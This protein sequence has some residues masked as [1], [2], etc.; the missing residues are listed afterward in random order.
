MSVLVNI[1]G[2]DI[3]T[4]TGSN[5]HLIRE[6]SGLDPWCCS[7]SQVKQVLGEKL[8]EVPAQDLWRLAY[9]GKLLEQ[10]GEAHHE[11]LDTREL[12]ELIDSLCIN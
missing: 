4:N 3:R 5:L 8:R 10:R 1:F 2:R 6:L 11:M 9:L 12:T 7:S